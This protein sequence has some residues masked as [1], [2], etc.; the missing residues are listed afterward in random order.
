M[1]RT[2]KA[3]PAGLANMG[4][5]VLSDVIAQP[6]R[7]LV[8]G[9]DDSEYESQVWSQVARPLGKS[10]LGT[11]TLAGSLP[12]S[13]LPG[14]IGESARDN[15]V[16]AAQEFNETPFE[17]ILEHAGNAALAGGLAAKPLGAAA[18]AGAGVQ[19][20]TPATLR[21]AG[22]LPEGQVG[23][24]AARKQRLIDL[25]DIA[26][27]GEGGSGA[28]RAALFS[29]DIVGRPYRAAGRKAADVR[30]PSVLNRAG[31][32]PTASLREVSQQFR[33][34]AP[35]SVDPIT[36][37]V[38]YRAA[39]ESTVSPTGDSPIDLD[40]PT[41]TSP[42]A[43]RLRGFANDTEIGQTLA[44][45]FGS[46]RRAGARVRDDMLEGLREAAR[47][48]ALE[49]DPSARLA[50]ASDVFRQARKADTEYRDLASRPELD[51]PDRIENLSPEQ[52]A[53]AG[54][55]LIEAPDVP[56]ALQ[57]IRSRLAL[58]LFEHSEGIER[59]SVVDQVRY[60]APLLGDAGERA[61]TGL[62]ALEESGA[63]PENLPGFARAADRIK[64]DRLRSLPANH[65]ARRAF[66]EEVA[67]H[68]TG[69]PAV[70][71]ERHLF[72]TGVLTQT[73]GTLLRMDP[74]TGLREPR[75]GEGR[76]ALTPE[77]TKR[78]QTQVNRLQH[79]ADQ[80]KA[81]V[82][83]LESKSERLR[84]PERLEALP[85]F[86]A[87]VREFDRSAKRLTYSSATP[88]QRALALETL[89]DSRRALNEIAE[90][91]GVRLP[92]SL[93]KHQD[94]LIK[95]GESGWPDFHQP[96]GRP[97]T[98]KQHQRAAEQAKRSEIDSALSK[99]Q[100]ARQPIGERLISLEARAA[101]D[102]RALVQARER[103][104]RAEEMLNDKVSQY[105]NSV[106][107]AP[108][109][110][111]PHLV[112]ARQ[113]GPMIDTMLRDSGM[114]SLA[115]ELGL[116]NLPSTLDAINEAGGDLGFLEILAEGGPRIEKVGLGQPPGG[117][118]RPGTLSTANQRRLQS[119][120]PV[121]QSYD[122]VRY[123]Q[124][125]GIVRN[126]IENET[127]R[128]V[129]DRYARGANQL[130]EELGID[131]D[132]WND[133]DARQRAQI[134]SEQ[135]YAEVPSTLGGTGGRWMHKRLADA[136][137]TYSR[138]DLF[139]KFLDTTLNPAMRGWKGMTLAL[140]P[141]W[142]L[143]NLVGNVM[144]GMVQGGIDPLEYMKTMA[145][146]SREAMRRYRMGM[147]P[148]EGRIT[149]EHAD[150][151]N[152]GRISR[153]VEDAAGVE[154]GRTVSM[155]VDPAQHVPGRV[156]Q[157]GG[158]LRQTARRVTTKS[159][160]F[161]N[162]VDN[163]NRITVALANAGS[164]DGV[165]GA[166]A[167]AEQALG[168]YARM[169]P[170]ERK[171]VR[172][173]FPFWAWQRHITVLTARQF[174]PQNITRTAMFSHL[175]TLAADQDEWREMLPEYQKGDIRVGGTDKEPLMLAT[176]GLN[177]FQDVAD[178]FMRG[179]EV[180]PLSG[181]MRAA[182]PV[183]GF[184]A[185]RMTGVST[186]T[187]RPFRSAV[188]KTDEWGREIPEPPPLLEHALQAFSPPQV[189]VAR[190]LSRRAL[191]RTTARYDS[192]EALLWE[193]A[194]QAPAW[195]GLSSLTG[196]PLSTRNLPGLAEA[197]QKA[198][199]RRLGALA[200]R[201]EDLRENR[202]HQRTLSRLLPGD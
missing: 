115:D 149:A 66:D 2:L 20:A 160:E 158:V 178:Q 79:R 169:T 92:D 132:A 195:Q 174:G 60:V 44:A 25:Q 70:A 67:L 98:L 170:F 101:V 118:L 46:G 173:A 135:G 167:L 183:P 8:P 78:Q 189:R 128:L 190:D 96:G 180:A 127:N 185:E 37:K 62:K 148:V 16:E 124:E 146:P 199:K 99:V 26:A 130:A 69:D 35:I 165:T 143:N 113:V 196:L 65:W 126:Q 198:E 194:H 48:K 73:S 90:A 111:R 41:P 151:L 9:G 22:R 141:A 147:D 134:L 91:A 191:G 163:L 17:F 74:E 201:E 145:G 105:R 186:F 34:S 51:L 123:R 82:N 175:A 164:P 168:N 154:S 7:Q 144:M 15:V 108:A 28:A 100:R 57:P 10:L 61:L 27:A 153:Q 89:T 36:G 200:R 112:M 80:T 114:S 177:P 120:A 104:V 193:E 55:A 81:R 32:G 19:R 68:R 39:R 140:R 58:D 18:R 161:N 121:E 202:K 76:T 142:H 133:L 84:Q 77:L 192:G 11:A 131:M 13:L 21:E 94:R 54:R 95:A 75:P 129:L 93:V 184:I 24:A 23:R 166:L 49:T 1:G 42:V 162:Y 171:Y 102:E 157:A 156:E 4:G 38:D 110:A 56:P 155:D 45:H 172:S 106:D 71:R 86:K 119:Q 139:T 6:L 109:V 97:K 88:E 181:A 138:E 3:L 72:E 125:L 103:A 188:P 176:R 137:E 5:A 179:G 182:G 52:A 40:V 83:Q 136:V 47:A 12:A 31:E 30:L 107:A 43:A 187:G 87:A 150:R 122:A 159:Y 152:M 197:Q 14:D 33:E 29:R 59:G 117:A 63:T 64:N 50:A 85:E 116:K 53:A